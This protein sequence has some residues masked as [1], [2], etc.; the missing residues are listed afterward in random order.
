[1][2]RPGLPRM[3]VMRAVKAGAS[4]L[5]RARPQGGPL[6]DDARHVA[7]AGDRRLLDA[8]L[9]LNSARGEAETVNALAAALVAATGC[10]AS[11]VMQ[12]RHAGGARAV[13]AA[14][15]R[16]ADAS[17]AAL[18]GLPGD[19]PAMSRAIE[20]GAAIAVSGLDADLDAIAAP[21]CAFPSWAA[22]RGYASGIA[23]PVTRGP[24]TVA[25]VYLFWSQPLPVAI[26][27]MRRVEVLLDLASRHFPAGAPGAAALP[28]GQASSPAH[29]PAG[30]QEAAPRDD[31]PPT[32]QPVLSGRVVPGVPHP[33]PVEAPSGPAVA[34]TQDPEL[35]PVPGHPLPS[36]RLPLTTSGISLDPARERVEVGGI[37]LALSSTEFALLYAVAAASGPLTRAELAAHAWPG[38]QAPSPNAID[39]ALCRLRKRLSRVP[40]GAGLIETVRAQGYRL[41]AP[42]PDA[43]DGLRATRTGQHA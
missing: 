26:E 22:D 39:V 30:I 31:A 9:Q 34:R 29:L 35:Q 10:D 40:G 2:N 8:I 28:V 37:R 3:A 24:E 19:S 32:L 4:L 12:S 27:D 1:M 16:G 20:N 13:V 15:F 21:G 18:T 11:A 25:A 6:P 41:C 38:G 42:P 5:R 14:H 36:R 17:G 7:G 23:A 43:P 33:E